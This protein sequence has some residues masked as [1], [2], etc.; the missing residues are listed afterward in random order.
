MILTTEQIREVQ[1]AELEILKEIDRVCKKCN[2]R[3]FISDGTLLGAV[4]HKGFIPWDD[5]ADVSMLRAD[6]EKFRKACK[7]ELNKEKFYFQDDRNTR[8]YRWGYGKV[9]MKGTEFI[10]PFQSDLAYEQGIFVDVFPLDGVPDDN[11]LRTIK[12]FECFVVRKIL[13]SKVGQFADKSSI[14]RKVYSLLAKIP[15]KDVKR[16]L[17]SMVKRSMKNPNTQLVRILTYDTATILYGYMR[18]WYEHGAEYEFEG[19][20]FTGI[21]EYEN[22]LSNFYGKYMNIPPDD[23]KPVSKLAKLKLPNS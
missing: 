21:K 8:G 10:R 13:W 4:R 20:T 11:I 1:L 14:K 6:Y 3:Y 9:R 19:Y 5:D 12:N 7:S 17:H 15:E 23:K 2:L 18:D 22:Y 16:Y